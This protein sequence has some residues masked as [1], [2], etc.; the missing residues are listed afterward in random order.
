M[1]R[2][3]VNA[4]GML[5][6]VLLQT[7]ASA[8]T[9]K[10]SGHPPNVLFICVDDLRPALGCYGDRI[11]RTPN[12]DALAR[13]GRTFLRAYVQEA[14]CGPSR[15]SVLTGQLPDTTGVVHLRHRF[16]DKLPDVI[17]LPQAF[18]RAGYRTASLGK[19]FSGDPRELDPQ[20]WTDGEFIGDDSWK[21]YVLPENQG[22][23][24]Q[25][26]YESPNVEDRAYA[27]GMLA[28]AAVRKM[29]ELS[30]A[31]KPFF[32]AV[33]FYK[34][35]LPF[36]APA[37]YWDLYQPEKF[38]LSSK[39]VLPVNIPQIAFHPHRELGGYR[40]VRQDEQLTKAEHVNLRHGYYACVSYID[41][42][43]GKLLAALETQGLSDNTV[44]VLW[45]DHGFAT[46]EGNRWCKGTNFELDTKVPLII[47]VPQ[48]RQAGK[49]SKALVEMVDVYPTLL[50]LAGIP[51]ESGLAGTSLQPILMDHKAVVHEAVLSQFIRPWSRDDYKQMGYSIRTD[52]H[53]YTRWVNVNDGK[54]VAEEFYDYGDS[55]S[56]YRLKSSHVEFRSLNHD[57]SNA[58]DKERHSAM[59]TEMLRV[60]L[61]EK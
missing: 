37:K 47:K 48:M 10:E 39:N 36:N 43:V 20:S 24:K 45:G 7:S 2:F 42:Q 25:A 6:I 15:A 21:K 4:F 18:S 26:A 60:R 50:S 29:E 14:V 27:D 40:G 56:V 41:A 12:M 32:L 38:V 17:T 19:V 22:Q 28:E 23:G 33:G 52:E 31:D 59:L 34:P 3:A 51:H 8:G 46:G 35:H 57:K 9:T 55:A 53:R 44:V 5:L 61:D 11:A 30:T 1:N 54:T 49:A 13:H 16:R 58:V